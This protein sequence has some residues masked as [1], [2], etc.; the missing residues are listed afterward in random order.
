MDEEQGS[1]G[2]QTYAQE[3]AADLAN[4]VGALESDLGA[5]H[6]VGITY[7]GT[8]ELAK[9]LAPVGHVLEPI[10]AG[11]IERNE[12]AGE[13]INFLKGVTGFSPT[14]DSRFYFNYHHTAA[15][16]FDKVV[17]RELNENAAVMSVLAYALADSPQPRATLMDQ[18]PTFFVTPEDF[19]RWLVEHHN[20]A[21]ELWVGFHKRATKR[22]SMTWP[23]S[24][25]QAL[26]F[27]WIDG[28]R[29]SID[30]NSYKIRFTPRR[31]RSKWS[32]VNVRRVQELIDSGL[33][34]AAGRKAF[35]ERMFVEDAHYSYEQRHRITLTPEQELQFRGNKT[36]W[37]FFNSQP[38][39]YRKAALWWI[40]S[41]KRAE[42]TNKRL[43]QLIKDSEQRRPIAPLDRKPNG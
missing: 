3:H 34:H 39:W 17:P 16:T 32:A 27:G 6:P 13:D 28:V 8:S 4:H 10:G 14:Q 40:V 7:T 37:E 19:R 12:E 29:K 26:C 42:T 30:E 25:D 21:T 1:D 31:A 23:E 5:G 18:A 2:A 38:P 22:S 43:L 20:R 15:D 36:A 24:V 41:A 33:V 11:L 9:W 35:E